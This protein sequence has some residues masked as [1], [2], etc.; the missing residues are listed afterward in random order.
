MKKKIKLPGSI[1]AAVVT[2]NR[3]TA[4]TTVLA[5]IV[6]SMNWNRSTAITA[7]AA[8]EAALEHQT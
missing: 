5:V 1:A 7:E 4:S 6:L 3:I 2:A 8:K